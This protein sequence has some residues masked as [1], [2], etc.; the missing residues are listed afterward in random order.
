MTVAATGVL[1]GGGAGAGERGRRFRLRLRLRLRPS[2]TRRTPDASTL[3]TPA[4]RR[5]RQRRHG[6]PLPLMGGP[7]PGSG[8][9]GSGSSFQ[10]GPGGP[11]GRHRRSEDPSQPVRPSI[12]RGGGRW[13]RR[14]LNPRDP[15]RRDHNTTID[16]RVGL[17]VSRYG[18]DRGCRKVS[19][20]R[21]ALARAADIPRSVLLQGCISQH[22]VRCQRTV[23]R[24][25]SKPAH[26]ATRSSRTGD[27]VAKS[28]LGWWIAAAVEAPSL[29][30]HFIAAVYAPQPHQRH[31]GQHPNPTTPFA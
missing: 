5:H 26:F 31:T 3:R 2:R 28:I 23:L 30:H 14:L 22:S 8:S 16:R 1:A 25:A 20:S 11:G 9:G 29:V 19:S 6:P 4:R 24:N 18:P 21:A 17:T 13:R 12:L 27:R 15:R 10:P 7:G